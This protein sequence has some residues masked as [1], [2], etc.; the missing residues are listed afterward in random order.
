MCIVWVVSG[1]LLLILVHD[2]GCG[3]GFVNARV[4]LPNFDHCLS[5]FFFFWKL[6]AA[7]SLQE[8]A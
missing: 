6:S 8:S 2:F 4:T 3:K 5:Q 7:E 1:A